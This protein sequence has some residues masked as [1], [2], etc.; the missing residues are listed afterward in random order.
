MMTDQTDTGSTSTRTA[1]TA[2]QIAGQRQAAVT[3]GKMLANAAAGG[4]AAIS[5]T[6]GP[7]GSSLVGRCLSYDQDRRSAMPAGRATSGL[8]HAAILSTAGP[9]HT[10]TSLHESLSSCV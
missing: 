1:A 4:L 7:A 6:V 3:L 8:R 9:A 5:W 2:E 10:V